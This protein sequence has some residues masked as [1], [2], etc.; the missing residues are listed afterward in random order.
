MRSRCV[1]LVLALSIVSSGC[2]LMETACHNVAVEMR[3]TWNEHKPGPR[4]PEYLNCPND[5]QEVPVDSR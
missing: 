4:K 3:E 2:G 1:L 5:R